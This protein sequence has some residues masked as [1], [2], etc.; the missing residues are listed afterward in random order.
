MSERQSLESLTDE[1]N[2]MAESLKELARARKSRKGIDP[3]APEETV[4]QIRAETSALRA[5]NDEAAAAIRRRAT[6]KVVPD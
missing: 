1:L 6:L 2:A 5:R 3:D 4:E